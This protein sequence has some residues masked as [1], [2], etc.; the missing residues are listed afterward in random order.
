MVVHG[1]G[2]TKALGG[3][4]NDTRAGKLP[5][6]CEPARVLFDRPW[7]M[8][9]AMHALGHLPLLGHASTD[10]SGKVLH[11]L[12]PWYHMVPH[13]GPYFPSPK[14]PTVPFHMSLEEF[15]F[16]KDQTLLMIAAKS[17]QPA[18]VPQE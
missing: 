13:F 17:C 8:H 7:A 4:C 5:G 1:L 6:R 16:E 3:H 9:W 18:E 15:G 2:H 12:T 14:F 10:P 11:I